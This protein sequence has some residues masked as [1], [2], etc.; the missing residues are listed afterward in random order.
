M[1]GNSC[2]T[3]GIMESDE[4]T[5]DMAKDFTAKLLDKLQDELGIRSLKV[6]GAN[7]NS[8][9]E[10]PTAF[11]I[12]PL[13]FK[14]FLLTAWRRSRIVHASRGRAPTSFSVSTVSVI[15]P[16]LD[17]FRMF[18]H[19]WCHSSENPFLAGVTTYTS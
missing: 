1:C 13:S 3:D 14:I 9:G 7:W 4:I 11:L 6:E 15:K 16:R 19:P 5:I 10:T 8:A 12:A 18:P 17:E 2:I